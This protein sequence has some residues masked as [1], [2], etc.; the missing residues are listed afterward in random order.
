MNSN[1]ITPFALGAAFLLLGGCEHAI[2]E[3]PN[4]AAFGEPNRQTMM[5]QLV[6]PEPV[7]DEPVQTSGEHA[8]QA[9]ERYRTDKVKRPERVRTTQG[10][11]GSGG[12]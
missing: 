9:A 3:P 4:A 7:Y 5:A 8:A 2:N 11:S 1:R 6:D 10:T 12:N